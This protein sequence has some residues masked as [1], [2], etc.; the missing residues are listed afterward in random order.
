MEGARTLALPERG[1]TRYGRKK[2]LYWRRR[3]TSA[4]YETEKRCAII[5]RAVDADAKGNTLSTILSST[6][7]IPSLA[8]LDTAARY[9]DPCHPHLSPKFAFSS[10]V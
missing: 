1:L 7:C 3:H 6:A 2:D 8:F 10:Y 4:K 5:V 9:I